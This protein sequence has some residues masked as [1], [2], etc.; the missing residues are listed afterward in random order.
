MFDA[1]Y[2]GMMILQKEKAY[3]TLNGKR[4]NGVV[5]IPTYFPPISDCYSACSGVA[6]ILQAYDASC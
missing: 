6:S 2:I 4:K 1:V 3:K 5:I